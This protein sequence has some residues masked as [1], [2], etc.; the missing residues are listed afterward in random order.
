MVRSYSYAAHAALFAFTVHAP[1]D[2]VRLES[3]ADAWQYWAAEAFLG[4]Y[5][6]TISDSPLVPRGAAWPALVR[7]F[8]LD[9]ALYELGYELNNRPDS[10][11]I[12]LMRI[13]KPVG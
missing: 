3:W 13:R 5:T 2:Y 10:V 4:G 6:S 11:R 9:K 1:D 7:A 12:P 8:V